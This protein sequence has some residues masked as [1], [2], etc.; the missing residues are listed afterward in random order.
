MCVKCLAGVVHL[1]WASNVACVHTSQFD[2]Q[3][4]ALW[5]CCREWEGIFACKRQLQVSGQ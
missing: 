5:M 1:L 2:L 3:F 4:L